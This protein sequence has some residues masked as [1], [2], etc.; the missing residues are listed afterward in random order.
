MVTRGLA[1]L[2]LAYD[3]I[4]RGHVFEALEEVAVQLTALRSDLPADQWRAFCRDVVPEHPLRTIIHQAPFT[5]RAF[6]K[7]R[8]YPGDAIVLDWIYGH[9]QLPIDA[10]PFVTELHR[11]EFQTPSCKSVRNRKGVLAATVDEVASRR[12]RPVRVLAVACGHLREA[13]KS[14]AV[15]T[16]RVAEY[17]ALDQ[18]R[19]S[20]AVA[21]QA[22]SVV[23]PIHGSVRGILANKISY[24]D[25]DFVYAAGLYDYL[26]DS[27]AIQLTARLFQMLA[28]GGRLIIANFNPDLRDIGYLEAY[29]DWQLIYRT[30]QQLA[31]CARAI[32]DSEIRMTRIFREPAGNIS[33]LELHRRE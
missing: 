30:D 15:K 32:T 25:L 5:K 11:W 10:D 23:R 14:A 6:D 4:Q 24:S 16:H 8:G 29:M 18:D 22:S 21:A 9:Q 7:P 33:F 31:E 2:D 12:Q 13:E 19:E 26:S 20:L 17:L 1:V 27:V 28:P 3:A